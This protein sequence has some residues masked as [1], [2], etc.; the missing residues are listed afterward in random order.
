MQRLFD[1]NVHKI[2]AP[3]CDDAVCLSLGKGLD[4]VISHSC[5]GHP[6]SGGRGAAALDMAQ[7]RNS[8]VKSQGFLDPFGNVI[9]TLHGALG[10]HD[11]VMGKPI[12]PRGTD[13]LH[14]VVLKVDF[15]FR[16]QHRSCTYSYANVH[17]KVSR[18]AAH[19]FYNRA[20]LMGLHGIAKLINAFDGGIGGGIKADG[21]AAPLALMKGLANLSLI[22]VHVPF[23][24]VPI[25]SG[26]LAVVVQIV[27][28]FIGC[29]GF[30]L[31]FN[32][33]KRQV[34][35]SGIGGALAWCIYLFLADLMGGIFLSTLIASVFIGVYSEIMA[36]V[37][38]APATIFFTSVAIALIPGA[39]L[40]YAMD[41]LL[42][43]D[44][45]AAS[46]N[47]NKALTIALAI[48]MGIVL[49]A[50]INKFRAEI[51]RGKG[52]A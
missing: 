44:M 9:C 34:I 8:R 32:M 13:L 49:V 28:A 33:K 24:I 17:G 42:E 51:K 14:H 29:I 10:H 31:L 15:F 43:K 12:E 1:V 45:N 36:K 38:K 26:S 21:F 48:S 41:S 6:I 7:D 18:V 16:N 37:N 11:H 47:A 30:A 5:G 39:S 20:A 19:H 52:N 50:V 40:Y 35:Y 46:F 2:A 27:T 23:F 25:R 22:N 4:C 3:K